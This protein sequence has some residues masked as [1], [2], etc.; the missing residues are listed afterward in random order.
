[1]LLDGR[2][3]ALKFTPAANSVTADMTLGAGLSGLAQDQNAATGPV[4]ITAGSGSGLF[5]GGSLGALFEVRDKIVPEFTARSTATP[6][7]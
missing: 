5:D 3:Y 6:T 1:M 2:V 7:T 4:A